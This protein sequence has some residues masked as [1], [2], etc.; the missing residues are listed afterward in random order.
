MGRHKVDRFTNLFFDRFSLFDLQLD[1]RECEVAARIL[2][3]QI[4]VWNVF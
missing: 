2:A 3:N 1:D 4:T